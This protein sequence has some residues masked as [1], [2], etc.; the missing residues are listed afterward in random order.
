MSKE[1]SDV[2]VVVVQGSFQTPLVYEQ[3]SEAIR[4]K[5]YVTF[6]PELPSCS[7]TESPNFCK[8]TLNDDSEVVK[9]V[10]HDLVQQKGKRVTVVMHSYGGLGKA[11]HYIL[12]TTVTNVWF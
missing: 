3:L 8:R 12:N 7:D 11:D 9:K 6:Q 10:L 4:A 1:P 5:G 2:A